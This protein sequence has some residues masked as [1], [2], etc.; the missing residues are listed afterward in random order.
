MKNNRRR[1]FVKQLLAGV[2]GATLLPSYT[3]NAS[4]SK[5]EIGSSIDYEDDSEAFWE[6]LKQQF[7]FAEGLHYFNNASLG[8]SPIPVQEATN[9][10]RAT[11]DGF[12]SKYMWGDWSDEKE[13]VRQKVADL[14]TVSNE[15][16][17]ITHNTTEGMNLIARSF[18]LQLGDEVI[19]A[20]HEHYS[21]TVP[22]KVWQESKGVKLVRPVLPILPE[23][24]EDIVAVYRNAITPKTKVI[25]MCHMVNTNG[26][27][28]PVKEI[29]EMA[30]KRG[31]LVA[32]DGAQSSGMFEIDLHDLGC[33]FYTASAHKWLFSP[34]GIS[35]FYAKKESQ[36]YLKPLV[37]AYGYDD[38]S[39]R[40][41]ENYNTRNLPEYLG[42]GAAIDFHT[43]IG[44]EKISKRSYELK[45]YFRN[46][47]KEH[48][49]FR[50]KTPAH[51]DLSCAIQT[52]EIIGKDVQDVKKQLSE[53]YGIDTR[54]MRTFGLN[55][56][57][58]SFAIFITKRDVDYLVKALEEIAG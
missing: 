54:P 17:A 21:G 4:T 26:M 15:E 32:V 50:F 35:I 51:D 10:F 31:I 34:K 11:L 42:L 44:K 2:T 48:P 24:V 43:K 28:L 45:H 18:D 38:P 16:I 46:K 58:I 3:A 36:H 55:G 29:S 7:S 1:S 12:P 19:L 9:T 8:P 22:W 53:N 40:R 57:R 27:I 37:V 6:Q 39:I 52:V 30:H 20:D 56:V 23:T 47:L 5:K 13:T 25:S 33:D 49:T 41:L 14:F